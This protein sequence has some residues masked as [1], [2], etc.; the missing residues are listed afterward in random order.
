[1]QLLHI[2]SDFV[3]KMME[4]KLVD[5]P[6]IPGDIQPN[7]INAKEYIISMIA[8]QNM[9][10]LD[11]IQ[12]LKTQL[13]EALDQLA[14]NAKNNQQENKK[15]ASE[16]KVNKTKDNLGETKKDESKQND[17][18]NKNS[19]Q[20]PSAPQNTPSPSTTTGNPSS[21]SPRPAPSRPTHF[22]K[23][24]TSYLRNPKILFVGDSVAH[25]ANFARVEKE[26]KTR[27]RT[28]KAYSS[29][30]DQRAK[31]PKKNYSDVTPKALV[32]TPEEDEYTHLVIAAPTVDISNIDT[33]NITEDVKAEMFKQMMTSSCQNM[34]YVSK[35]DF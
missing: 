19:N 1:M 10:I 20:K 28:V 26:T 13:K 24:K 32:N 17:R 7:T 29:V 25:N 11:E 21:T 27:I 16:Q 2:Q 3:I 33:S 35:H 9:E 4:H 34:G 22:R 23:K 14:V 30:N 15:N 5:H 31:W 6:E 12:G 8:E 18:R